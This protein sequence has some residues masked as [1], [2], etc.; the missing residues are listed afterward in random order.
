MRS[1]DIHLPKTL[2]EALEIIEANPEILPVAGGSEIV[3]SQYG[4]LIDFPESILSISKLRELRKTQRTEQF[5]EVGACTTMTGLLGLPK[6]TLPSPLGEAIRGIGNLGIRNIATLGGNLC[7]HRH[8]MDLWPF[9]AS[10]DA[11]IEIRSASVS[12]WASVYHLADEKGSPALPPRTLVTRI[13]IPLV[14]YNFTFFKKIGP[15]GIPGPENAYFVC[16]GLIRHGKVDMFKLIFSGA[17]AFRVK[18]LEMLLL[19]RRI[20][21]PIRE[22][23]GIAQSYKQ[24]LEKQ[25]WFDGRVFGGI[26]DECLSRLFTS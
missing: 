12:R 1:S 25:D 6:G 9:L 11:Q 26:L 16:L 21:G 17:K 15:R 14:S 18:D 22:I 19:G 13:R 20:E 4:R 23:Q 5:L 24:S 7:S 8:F 10:M 3:G 2:A